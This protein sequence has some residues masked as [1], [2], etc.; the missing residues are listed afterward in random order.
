M[1]WLDWLRERWTTRVLSDPPPPPSSPEE[2]EEAEHL[3]QHLE[4]ELRYI[5]TAYGKQDKHTRT[6]ER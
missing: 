6:G 5:Q 1:N 4:R 2:R 3:I